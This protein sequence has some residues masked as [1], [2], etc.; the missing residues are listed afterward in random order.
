MKLLIWN[1]NG[2]R[3]IVKRRIENQSFVQFIAN[4]DIIALNETKIDETKINDHTKNIVPDGFHIYSAHSIKKGYSGVSII[5]KYQPIK[6]IEPHF[7]DPEGRIV[8]LE[9]EHFILIG[10]YVPNA[11]Q[12]RNGSPH[13]LH[14]KTVEWDPQFQLLCATLAKTKPIIIL[15][16]MNV[17]ATELDIH[18]P[19]RNRH[20]AGFTDAERHNFNILLEATPV[21][22]VWRTLHKDKREYTYFDYRTKARQRNAGWRL[23]Y[24]LISPVLMRR[25]TKCSILSNVEGSDHVPMELY[26]K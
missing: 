2:L 26:I 4:F 20:H 11:G 1:V 13:R 7:D 10:V 9:Y 24:A 16:D 21:I 14:Y 8:V 23:D 12:Q 25:I 3:A 6:R 15:G 5:T 18:N 17:A 19:E 22:D